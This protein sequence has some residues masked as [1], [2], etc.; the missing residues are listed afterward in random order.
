MKRIIPITAIA[1]LS[2]AALL[3]GRAAVAAPVDTVVAASTQG[4]YVD[5]SSNP[6]TWVAS[7]ATDGRTADIRR[8]IAQQPMA[9]WFGDWTTGVGAAVGGYVGAAANAGKIPILVAYDIPHR[10]ACGGLSSGG[11][12]DAGA[13]RTWIAAFADSIKTRPAV[14]VL[15][16]DALAD[17]SCLT[18]AQITERQQLLAF[19]AQQF[20]D[21][22]VNAAVY[23]DAGNSHYAPAP[24]IATRLIASGLGQV[25]GFALNVSNYHPTSEETSYGNTVNNALAARGAARKP[26]VVDTSRNGKGATGD[27]CNP[28]GRLLGGTSRVL[29]TSGTGLEA[30]LWVK[31]PG[32]S[33]GECGS[34]PTTPAGTFDPELA[35]DLVHGY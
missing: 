11:A 23:L 21:R 4:F 24:D 31:T 8:A 27:W 3:S 30:Q 2:T 34:A 17:L 9:R 10:D 18:T 7:H 33:D 16:P 5:P 25:R 19:A 22:A 26:F 35:Y 29:S 28:P 1:L 13:Y 32:N 14:V 20:H 6:A 15:E 12:A